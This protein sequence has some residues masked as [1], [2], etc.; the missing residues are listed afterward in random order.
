MYMVKNTRKTCH[1]N[2]ITSSYNTVID[3]SGAIKLYTNLPTL[4]ASTNFI[5]KYLN[6]NIP[7]QNE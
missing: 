7:I 6:I 3:S 1:Y 5:I 2:N 4:S